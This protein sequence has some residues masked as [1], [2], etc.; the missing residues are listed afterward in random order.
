MTALMCG[1]VTARRVVVDEVIVRK[2][3]KQVNLVWIVIGV[4]PEWQQGEQRT[5][6]K[7]NEMVNEKWQRRSKD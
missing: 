1:V 7:I 2:L 5:K 3:I 4:S 6:G